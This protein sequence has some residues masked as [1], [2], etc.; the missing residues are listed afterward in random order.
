MLQLYAHTDYYTQSQSQSDWWFAAVLHPDGLLQFLVYLPHLLALLPQTESVNKNTQH[1]AASANLPEIPT[2]FHRHYS[3]RG[4]LLHPD[5]HHLSLL[6]PASDNS[7]HVN[8]PH[9]FRPSTDYTYSLYSALD[10]HFHQQCS[11]PAD[12]NE[13][14]PVLKHAKGHRCIPHRKVWKLLPACP[15]LLHY[16]IL[17]GYKPSATGY[18]KM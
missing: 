15:C 9:K 13:I 7:L 4:L 12:H 8:L 1:P 14:L 2:R 5:F 18:I 10:F 17:P 3:N 6:I 11:I 16:P